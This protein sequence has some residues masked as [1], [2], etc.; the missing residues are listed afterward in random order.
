MLCGEVRLRQTP[1][2]LLQVVTPFTFSDGDVFQLYLQETSG[3][4]VRLTDYGHT[5][6]H[7]SY[8]NDLAKFKEGTRGKLFDQV[9]AESGVKEDGGQLFLDTDISGVGARILT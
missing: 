8:E 2:G 3:G 4:G 5:F 1:Q 7:L 9:L 6:M